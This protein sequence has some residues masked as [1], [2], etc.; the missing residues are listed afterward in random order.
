MTSYEYSREVEEDP[1]ITSMFLLHFS[2]LRHNP[3]SAP[4]VAVTTTFTP[5]VRETVMVSTTTAESST[6]STIP[7]VTETEVSTTE[8]T[9]QKET[10]TPRRPTTTKP[11]AS[12][13]E[14]NSGDLGEDHPSEVKVLPHLQYL[15]VKFSE[16]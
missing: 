7:E 8:V 5:P 11:K 6:T 13:M 9:L 2:S 15:Y 16:Y 4:L 14:V 3:N 1:T 12:P 10:T